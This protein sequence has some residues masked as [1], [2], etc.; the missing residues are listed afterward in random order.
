MQ[1]EAAM[2]Q[3]SDLDLFMEIAMEQRERC[4]APLHI[5]SLALLLQLADVLRRMAQSRGVARCMSTG[6]GH[7][8]GT[9]AAALI[10][11]E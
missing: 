2:L 3:I 9:P 1:Y 7:A 5:P 8:G 11:G 10:T 6:G 4:N